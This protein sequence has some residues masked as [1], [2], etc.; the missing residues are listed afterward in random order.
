ME[1]IQRAHA[2]DVWNYLIR[3][4]TFLASSA[5]F[6]GDPILV[7]QKSSVEVHSLLVR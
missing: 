6:A 1:M 3:L 4:L 2:V 5:H 7:L